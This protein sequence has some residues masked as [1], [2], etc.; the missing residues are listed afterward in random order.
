MS[1]IKVPY[2]DLSK[3]N[4]PYL[5]LLEEASSEIIREGWYIL[6]KNVKMFEQSFST[7]NNVNFCVG[8]ASGLDAIILGLSVFNFPEN[9]KVLVPSNAYIACILGI[10]RA[11]LTPVLVEPDIATYNINSETL[12]NYYTE[13]CVAI[14]AVHMYGRLCPMNEIMEFAKSKKLKVI[15]DCA[16]SH[17][18]QINGIMA[19]SFGD[20]GAFSFYPT[21]NLG[22]LGDAGALICKEESIYEKLIALRNYGSHKKYENRYLGWNSRLDEIQAAF[23]NIKIKDYEKVIKKK[24]DFAQ[25]YFDKLSKINNIQLPLPAIEEHVW[26]IFNILI[27]DRNELKKYLS[28]KGINTEIHYPISPSNQDG[29]KHLFNNE[30]FPI[31]DK[32]HRNTLSLPISTCLNENQIEY[33]CEQIQSFFK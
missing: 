7:I 33:V 6:G 15:E 11:G 28:E 1:H 23:L 12:N 27:E 5:K 21:K 18:A 3:I 9:S 16:Q 29:Y 10:I 30:N 8:V 22:A 20:V 4:E 31:T 13:D 2:E 17:F 24:R 19:G 32:I 25:I 26:H 14:L